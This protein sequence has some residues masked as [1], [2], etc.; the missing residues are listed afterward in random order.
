VGIV[1]LGVGVGFGADALSQKNQAD[2]HCPG[3][4]CDPTG[5]SLISSAKTSAT[6]STIGLAV[7]VVGIGAGTWLLVRSSS[8]P[9]AARATV[10][11]FVAADRAGLAVQGAW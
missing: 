7:G 8:S 10:A 5:L 1:A 9:S 11:P 3:R 2:A 4:L 6:I